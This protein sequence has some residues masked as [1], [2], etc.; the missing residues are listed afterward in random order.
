MELPA[1]F[2]GRFADIEQR[3]A[4]DDPYETLQIAALLRQLLLDGNPLLDQVNRAHRLIIRYEVAIYELPPL[5]AERMI[6]AVQDGLDPD[7]K[8]RQQGR[9]LISR[10]EFLATVVAQYGDT[11]YSVKDI[12]Q[13]AAHVLGAVHAGSPKTVE[14]ELLAQMNK[15]FHVGGYP[16]VLRSLKAIARICLKAWRPLRELVAA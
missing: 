14:E 9:K 13:C 12:I 16:I 11:R 4:Q 1:L 3:V 2:L 8:P 5:I 6:W 10:D 7:T 15:H